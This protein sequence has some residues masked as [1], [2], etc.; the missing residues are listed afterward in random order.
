[1]KIPPDIWLTT[2]NGRRPYFLH[3]PQHAR[4]FFNDFIIGPHGET[5]GWF[6]TSDGSKRNIDDMEDVEVVKYALMFIRNILEKTLH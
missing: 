1:M 6:F 4:E 5:I 3:N 2:P